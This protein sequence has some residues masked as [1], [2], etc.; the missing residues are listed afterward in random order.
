MHRKTNFE[1][2]PLG[3]SGLKGGFFKFWQYYFSVGRIEFIKYQ[4]PFFCPT[5]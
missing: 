5:T 4:K 2:F 3:K 1:Y